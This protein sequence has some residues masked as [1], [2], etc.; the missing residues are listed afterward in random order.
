M[1]QEQVLIKYAKKEVKKSMLTPLIE[2]NKI[3]L[4]HGESGSG[5]TTYIIQHLNEHDITPVLWDFDDNEAEELESNNCSADI[6]DGYA[7]LK[8]TE[9]EIKTLAGRVVVFDT[10]QLLQSEVGGEE[11]AYHMLKEFTKYG[12]TVVIVAHTVPYS[13]KEDRPDVKDEIYKHIKGRLYIRKTSLKNT[14]EYHLI[15][16]KVRG[17]KGSKIKLLREDMVEGYVK[18]T[19]K[20]SK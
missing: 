5:K 9:D 1:E 18:R 13:G 6:V 14:I 11:V 16:E 7:M 17:Y 4:L 10:W 2:E 8:A 19:P 20:A 15:I 12:I 3:M